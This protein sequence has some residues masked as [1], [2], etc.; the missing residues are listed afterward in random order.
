M[1]SNGF[2]M[3]TKQKQGK[4]NKINGANFETRVRKDLEDKG[5][6]VCKWMNQVDLD[7]N[8]LIPAKHKFSGIGRPMAIGTGFPDFIA[9]MPLDYGDYRILA[10]E[11]K[12]NGRLT[13][14][15]K[16]K[17]DWLTKNRIFSTIW[18]AKKIKALNRIT[19]EYERYE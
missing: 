3:L 12:S 19:I 2:K 8:K 1:H 15:E 11:S 18:I 13:K 6:I 9:F 7:N 10:I 16:D 5:W 4:R 14:I 17:C